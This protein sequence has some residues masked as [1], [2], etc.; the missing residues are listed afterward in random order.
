[1]PELMQAKDARITINK[2]MDEEVPKHI[3]AIAES[4][5]NAVRNNYSSIEYK[6]NNRELASKIISTLQVVYGYSAKYDNTTPYNH[7]IKIS[8]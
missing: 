6:M 3:K 8:W 1:M 4:I 5:S 2:Q 7:F